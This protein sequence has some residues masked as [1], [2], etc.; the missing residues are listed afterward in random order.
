[1]A[2]Q[3]EVVTRRLVLGG[4]GAVAASMLVAGCDFLSRKPASDDAPGASRRMGREAPELAEQV[5]AGK[6]PR[7][8]DRLPAQPVVIEPVERAGPYGGTWRTVI[9]GPD[10]T[11]WFGQLL[12]EPL[13]RWNDR[14]T[15]IVPNVAESFTA[16]NDGKEYVVRL[17][18]GLRWS[19]G[20]PFGAADVV[21]AQ[22]DVANNPDMSPIQLNNPT[23]EMVDDHTVRFTF[24][25]PNSLF[26]TIGLGS[27]LTE[28]PAHYL[29]KFHKEYAPDI[30]AIV[31]KEGQSDWVE[32]F[33]GKS[34]QWSN[35]EL[36]RLHAWVPQS[37]FGD[38]QR[39][40]F[41]RNPYY[42]KTDPGGRQL[43][44]ID[45]IAFE[46]VDDNPE[47]MLLKG[48]D[49]SID[50]HFRHFNI[51]RN[52][53][54]LA[55]DRERG[56]YRFFSTKPEIMNS[57]MIVL[58]L[59][60][61]DPVKREI[62][63][64]R[65]FRIGLSHALNRQDLVNAVYQRQ[66]EPWQA[67]PRRESEFFDEEFAKQYTEYDPDHANEYLDRAGYA[68]RDDDGLR[69]GPDGKPIK[70]SV[71]FASG[72]QDRPENALEQV[73][74]FWL[75]VGVDA[76][77]NS[78]D[79]SLLAIRNDTNKDDAFAWEGDGGLNPIA[80]PDW[81]FPDPAYL[82]FGRL[83]ANWY[84]SGGEQGEEPPEPIKRQMDLYDE[85]K[86]NTDS[87]KQKDLM[88]EV[89]AIAKEEFWVLGT[90][91]MPDSYGIAKNS[92]RNV[93]TTIID[94][95]QIHFQIDVCQCFIEQ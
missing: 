19:D 43:P 62:F 83:W 24:A 2:E 63:N 68:D 79:R 27:A 31:E 92:F 60:H 85:I 57:V 70:F 11:A 9:L 42:W 45:E 84:E 13:V 16:S 46:I 59:T 94:P 55:R 76:S 30:D 77:P 58:N 95:G 78:I 56:D 64:N 26:L 21:F 82:T 44:Y 5:K 72:S 90:V 17:R 86:A 91:V 48:V 49:G 10:D 54:V 93:P 47:V 69:L 52:K 32:L 38:G 12:L 39:I 66:G 23:A 41:R 50:M 34:D 81:F 36:P 33:L 88:R 89:L 40:I 1:M 87:G 4:G 28:R 22:N 80:V 6:L 75:A 20:E 73:R 3:R 8:P 71:N 35:H 7:L 15:E 65:D 14:A 25:R 37:A 29:K 61:E 18:P 53:P 67:A 51:A 74:R